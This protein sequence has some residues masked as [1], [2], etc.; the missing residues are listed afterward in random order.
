MLTNI[1]ALLK[2]I[3]G[4]IETLGPIVAQGVTDLGPVVSVMGKIIAGKS[5]SDADL[6][7]L[8]NVADNLH[9]AI[10]SSPETED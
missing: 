4:L 10:Q 3:L 7:S 1:I 5:L 9:Q 6:Q 8:Q 2:E